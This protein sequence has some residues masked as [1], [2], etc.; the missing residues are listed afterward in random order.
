MTYYPIYLNLRGKRA[1]VIGG[2][3]VAERKVA[4]LLDSGASI[5]VVSPQATERL[6]ALA[7][8]GLI[9]WRSRAYAS[10]DCGGAHLVFAAT[11]DPAVTAAVFQECRE[12]G[13]LIN[14]ADEPELCDFIMPAVVR[15]GDLIVAISTGG[16]SPALAA[17]LRRRLSQVIGAEYGRLLTLMSKVRPEIRH[18]IHN[19]SNRK[20]LH[21]RILRSGVLRLLRR[22]DTRG[23]EEL[24][25]DIIDEFAGRE[26]VTQ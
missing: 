17:T 18:R 21:Y 16:A 1:L 26:T 15:R 13:V 7:H 12:A 24:V 4:S 20:D 14:A 6:A 19:S 23:A 22:H 25:H 10:G 11:D 9:Q 3:P 8:A 5:L 2:G